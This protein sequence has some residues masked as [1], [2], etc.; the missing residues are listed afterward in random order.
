VRSLLRYEGTVKEAIHAFKFGGVSVLAS[1]FAVPLAHLL[2]AWAPPVE[3]LVPVPSPWVRERTRGYNPAHLLAREVGRI[4]GLPVLPGLLR[5]R[6]TPPQATLP[7]ERRYQQMA[8]AVAPRR[9]VNYS[10]LLLIDDV[11]TTG[12]TLNACA[13]ALLEAGA[14]EVWA[15]TLAREG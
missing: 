15:L 13:H 4:V 3:A 10:S 12:A 1:C 2:V 8:G 6:W 7:R 14:K 5:R 11:V 9:P